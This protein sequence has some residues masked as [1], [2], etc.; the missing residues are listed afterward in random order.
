VLHASSAEAALLLV[1]GKRLAL[2]TLDIM[3]PRMDGWELL[4][5]LKQTPALAGIP[6]VIVSIMADRA[7]GIAL[8]AAHVTSKPLSRK[9]LG[10]FLAELG[11]LPS[12]DVT[13]P[14]LPV[15]VE[16]VS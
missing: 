8:G 7:K 1:D 11:L 12:S 2:I 10:G 6:V 5:R 14:R 16:P 13:P 3:L 9:E 15:V 4:R